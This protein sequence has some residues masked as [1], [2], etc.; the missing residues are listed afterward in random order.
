MNNIELINI[1]NEIQE[2]YLNV[3]KAYY[4][5][6]KELGELENSM[7]VCQEYKPI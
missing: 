2:D 1:Y 7:M 5:D 3:I 6:D 4:K